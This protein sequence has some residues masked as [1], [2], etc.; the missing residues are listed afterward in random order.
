M[1]KG[2]TTRLP[3][4]DG[5]PGMEIIWA[6]DCRQ[7]FNQGVMLAQSWLDN[8]RSGWL[9]ATMIAERDLLPCAIERRAFEVGFLSR[10]HQRICSRHCSEQQIRALPLTL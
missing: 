2:V 5:H 10:I 3:S 6:A 1:S 8:A 7:A 4:H 9:W